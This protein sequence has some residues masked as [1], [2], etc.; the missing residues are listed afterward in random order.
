MAASDYR[1]LPGTAARYKAVSG[2]TKGEVISKRAHDE[3][4]AREAGFPGLKS[5]QAVKGNAEY[6]RHLGKAAAEHGTPRR[7]QRAMGSKFNRLFAAAYLRPDGSVRTIRETYDNG[8]EL[9]DLLL[10]LGYVGK[11]DQNRYVKS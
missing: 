9:F 10:Y 4:R 5:Y 11:S 6:K 1:R 3:M 8:Q 7:E 2:P